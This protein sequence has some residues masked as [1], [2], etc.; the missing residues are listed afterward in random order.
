MKKT[1]TDRQTDRKTD[2]D[3]NATLHQCLADNQKE[4]KTVNQKI[5]KQKNS[6]TKK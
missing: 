4:I 6:E 3:V 2:T 1:G 5:V